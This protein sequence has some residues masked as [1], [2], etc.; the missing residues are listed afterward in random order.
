MI[1][2]IITILG[3]ILAASSFIVAKKPD[4]REFIGKLAPYQGGIGIAMIVIGIFGILNLISHFTLFIL[5]KAVVDLGLGFL[6]GFSLLNRWFLSKD[7]DMLRKAEDLK[8]KLVKYEVT[9]GIIAIIVGT[10]RLLSILF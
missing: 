4:A 9:G 10:L 5:V 6:L 7:V 2:A 1:T 3:G 8:M